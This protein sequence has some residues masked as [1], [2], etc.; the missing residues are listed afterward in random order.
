MGARYLELVILDGSFSLNSKPI[1][2]TG[3][4]D[5]QWQ[6]SLNSIDLNSICSFMSK[7]ISKFI[8]LRL[9]I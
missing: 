2:T 6:T 3:Y 9:P 4:R 8:K 1:V 5:G 7:V